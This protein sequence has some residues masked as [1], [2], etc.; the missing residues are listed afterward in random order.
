MTTHY[1]ILIVGGGHGGAQAAI[2]FRHRKFA[3]T[4]GTIGEEPE[5]P[6]AR[7]LLSKEHLAQEKPFDRILIRPAQGAVDVLRQGCTRRPRRRSK[8]AV[9][10]GLRC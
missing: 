7:P 1:D 3:D 8:R 10:C 2:T 9:L 6:Y 5:L 4:I